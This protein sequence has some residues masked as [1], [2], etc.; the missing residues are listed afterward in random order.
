MDI[1]LEN[2]LKKANQM[3]MLN[4]IH[5]VKWDICQEIVKVVATRATLIQELATIVV[6]QA[7]LLETATNVVKVV[8]AVIVVIDVVILV[9]WHVTVTLVKKNVITVNNPVT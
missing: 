1:M 4:V 7:T 6:D 9:T 5:V 8:V 2:V 3:G